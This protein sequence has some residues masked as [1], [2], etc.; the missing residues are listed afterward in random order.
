M[1]EI[2]KINFCF[3]VVRDLTNTS[4]TLQLWQLKLAL[5]QGLRFKVVSNLLSSE[6]L[7]ALKYEAISILNSLEKDLSTSVKAYLS[8]ENFSF[9][10]DSLGT[11]LSTYV[12]FYNI[13]F[14]VKVSNLD[15]VFQLAIRLESSGYSSE[16]ISKILHILG[17]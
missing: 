5:A 9:C 11:Q 6:T 16:S 12:T 3:Q 15:Q 10:N 1:I 8:G 13:P 2:F 4:S 17:V 7:L 14:G